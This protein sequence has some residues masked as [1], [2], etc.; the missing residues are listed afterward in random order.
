MTTASQSQSSTTLSSVAGKGILAGLAGGLIF[1]LMMA[2][3][4][5]LPMVGMLVRQESAVVGFIVHM[6]ISAFIGAV[7]GVVISRFPSNGTTAIAG[8]IVNGIVWWVLGALVMMPLLLGMSNMVFVIGQMQ[9]MSLLGHIIYGLVTAFV[10]M[11]LVNR[12]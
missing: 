3:M 7:Y 4:N 2:M 1:G 6:L 5:M 9:W 8:G 10:F 12:G 11:Y